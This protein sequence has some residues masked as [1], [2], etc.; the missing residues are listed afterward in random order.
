MIITINYSLTTI[1]ISRFCHCHGWFQPFQPGLS[2]QISFLCGQ[3]TSCLGLPTVPGGNCN[4]G[5]SSSRGVHSNMSTKDPWHH[6]LYILY[7]YIYYIYIH[8]MTVCITIICIYI[9][10][11]YA[12]IVTN[13]AGV[14]H[15][16]RCLKS[17]F[18]M[19]PMLQ[20]PFWVHVAC[21]ATTI[22][23]VACSNNSWI[24]IQ[25]VTQ[26]HSVNLHSRHDLHSL[27]LL[28]WAAGQS[29]FCDHAIHV[30]DPFAMNACQRV[31]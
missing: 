20:W 12:A 9:Y 25:H 30:E 15:V 21:R 7:L 3:I 16:A 6:V 28:W 10:M 27:H 1:V 2:A 24:L 26:Q 8:S 17:L 13:T 23:L 29:A 31:W 22:H 4:A 11:I 19:L 18:C 5:Y 14:V